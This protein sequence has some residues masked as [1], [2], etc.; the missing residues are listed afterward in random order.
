MHFVLAATAFG[1]GFRHGIDWDHI[2]AITDITSSQD[3]SRRSIF[4][5]TLYAA[6][7]ALVVLALGLAAIVLGERLPSGV[8]AIMER[9]VGAT[10]LALGAYVFYALVRY[11]RDFRMRS[12]CVLLFSGVRRGAPRLR[13]AAPAGARVATGHET[14]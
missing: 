9:V 7:H 10:L 3:T 2:A 11:G 12:R 8:D 6:G 14:W 13:V 4:L 1:F 5:A